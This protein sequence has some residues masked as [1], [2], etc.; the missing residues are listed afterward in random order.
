[1]IVSSLMFGIVHM[2]PQQA[3]NAAVVGLVIGLLAVHSR[4]LFPAIAFHLLSNTIS[5]LHATN[6]FGL[7]PDGVFLSEVN[8]QLRYEAPTLILCSIAVSVVVARMIRDLKAEQQEKH[9]AVMKSFET[10][11]EGSNIAAGI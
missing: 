2:I 9:A 4:S 1:M 6:G 5:S 10:P 8:G 11:V 3:F 7:R